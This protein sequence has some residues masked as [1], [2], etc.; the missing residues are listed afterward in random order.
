MKVLT[1]GN[2]TNLITVKSCFTPI[3]T[4]FYYSILKIT[5]LKN[6]QKVLAQRELYLAQKAAKNPK[7]NQITLKDT[8][9]RT[10]GY[11]SEYIIVITAIYIYIFLENSLC[12]ITL[13]DSL[14]NMIVS[15]L[16]P[17]STVEDKGFVQFLHVI[18]PKYHPPSHQTIM[19]N[20]LL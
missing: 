17:V 12:K 5:I 2:T 3:I 16:Q 6:T 4:I 9:A 15:D 20:H 1:S 19:C 10:Q 11:S 14:E 7:I 18:D 8:L 13:N